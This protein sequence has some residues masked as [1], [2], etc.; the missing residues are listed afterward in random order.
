MTVLSFVPFLPFNITGL[1]Y[2]DKNDDLSVTSISTSIFR[3]VPISSLKVNAPLYLYNMSITPVSFL[4]LTDKFY[5]NLCTYLIFPCLIYFSFHHLVL[6]MDIF[7][8]FLL[9]LSLMCLQIYLTTHIKHQ[10]TQIYN[11][12]LNSIV[13]FLALFYHIP[14]ISNLI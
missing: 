6:T 2:A 3:Q 5:L 1:E 14:L 7:P 11:I 10:M 13:E 8:M 4:N 9:S 12:Y